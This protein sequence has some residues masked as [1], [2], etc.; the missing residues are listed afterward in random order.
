MDEEIIIDE[1]SGIVLVLDQTE[2]DPN[3]YP[4]YVQYTLDEW[5]E[6]YK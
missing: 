3:G 4:L 2:L 1:N 5:N 6:M